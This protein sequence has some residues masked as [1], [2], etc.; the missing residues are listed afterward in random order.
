MLI[1]CPS[2]AASYVID[3][4]SL[5]AAIR[6]VRCVRCKTAWIVNDRKAQIDV[7]GIIA[8][9][10]VKT[11]TRD[12]GTFSPVKR[13][14][15][16][17]S[18]QPTSVAST[19]YS[20]VDRRRVSMQRYSG[21]ILT[22]AA[23]IAGVLFI[24]LDKTANYPSDPKEVEVSLRGTFGGIDKFRTLRESDRLEPVEENN[25]S[26]KAIRISTALRVGNHEVMRVQP[27]LRIAG[28][29]LLTASNRPADISANSAQRLWA[30]SK[31]RPSG[32]DS[33]D[34]NDA[35]GVSLYQSVIETARR[36]QVP[37][38]I[39]NDLL[40]IYSNGV[41]FQP[42][43][44]PGDAFEVLFAGEEETSSLD[45]RNKVLYTALTVGGETKKF[46]RYQS[47]DDN[48]VDYYDETGKSATKLVVRNPVIAGIVS[49]GFGPRRDPFLGYTR[50]HTGVDWA[51]PTGTPIHASGNG[52]VEIIG[53]EFG[54]G[55][56]IRIRHTKRYETAYGHMTA[57]AR[58]IRVGTR[59][60][61]G[62]VIGFVG[63]T[64]FSTGHHLHYEILVD[65]RFVDPM[66][67][68]LP[69][70]RV[71][72][73]PMLES[74]E[75]EREQIDNLNNNMASRPLAVASTQSLAR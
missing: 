62:Q 59:V 28:N 57:Y 3:P 44:Q 41:D 6:T 46:Y 35:I 71:L 19:T 43:I 22:G 64:G 11:E 69:R 32:D 60:R 74:F 14:P 18:V 9:L 67:V 30:E 16:P 75:R 26:H 17:A 2:C 66:R 36:D 7:I 42:K 34:G 23:L 45:N 73:G 39:I 21:M 31:S 72:V 63:S 47:L 65:G 58:N 8:D 1:V 52:V 20:F 5:G 24:V 49:S 33:S 56:Y 10:I 68:K 12:G 61:Q 70:E 40:R 38:S 27:L 29:L 50:M 55:K 54:Y 37:D 15:E 53:W 51:V 4:I 48:I 13:Q 25:V